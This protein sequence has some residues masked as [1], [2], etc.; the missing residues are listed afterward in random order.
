MVQKKTQ[1][2]RLDVLIDKFPLHTTDLRVV[3]YVYAIKLGY[4]VA[5][6]GSSLYRPLLILNFLFQM[7]TNS[8]EYLLIN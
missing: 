7:K 6:G 2:F 5:N 4:K 3:Q 8:C 1:L